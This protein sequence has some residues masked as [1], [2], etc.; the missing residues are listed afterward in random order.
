M[1]S[2]RGPFS[3]ARGDTT[4]PSG[5]SLNRNQFPHPHQVVGRCR[6]GEDPAHF[7]DAAMFQFAQQRDV[8][9]PA[10]ALLDPLAF[11][12]THRR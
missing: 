4:A 9:Q 1:C 5:R 11:L 2:F 8:F 10:E 3:C 12:L 6:E 7:E